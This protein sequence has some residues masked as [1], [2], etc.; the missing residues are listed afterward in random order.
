MMPLNALYSYDPLSLT[1]LYL[2]LKF[3]ETQHEFATAT[4]FV[5]EH[6]NFYYLITNAHNVTRV[7][8][9]TCER[10]TKHAGFPDVVESRCFIKHSQSSEYIIRSELFSVPLYSDSDLSEP[11]WYMHP[12][13]GY[14]VDVIAIPLYDKEALPSHIVIKP[15]NRYNFVSADFPCEISDDVFILGY[16]FDISAGNDF[17]I[18]KRGSVAT[19]PLLDLEKLPKLL[20]D[21]A[22]RPG[23]SGSPVIYQ[24][25]GIHLKKT[26]ENKLDPQSLLGQIRGFLGIYSGRLGAENEFQAQLGIVWK[27]EVITEILDA[28]VKG[29]I[30]FQRQ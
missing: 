21:T 1:T 24:R 27:K 8:P 19:E 13:F 11:V 29:D 10:V 12:V 6:E 5:Y 26:D 3:S 9:S 25:N 20:I 14:Q 7:N 22:T 17:P 2:H 30:S 23:M 16:P 15:I 28:K 18:W 4:G